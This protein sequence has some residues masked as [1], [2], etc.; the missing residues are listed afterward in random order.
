MLKYM[1]HS[2][3]SNHSDTN[4]NNDN[5]NS[6]SQHSASNSHNSNSAF[7]MNYLVVG[8]I[9][10]ALLAGGFL[11]GKSQSRNTTSQPISSLGIS[12]GANLNN[13]SEQ[14]VKISDQEIKNLFVEWNAALQTKNPEV[15]VKKYADDAVLL[16]TLSNTP[17]TNPELIK[18]YF[19]EFLLKQPFGTINTSTVKSDCNT[20]YDVG[21][22]T[23]GI[24]DPKTGVK[25][26]VPARYSYI[27]KNINGKWL[28]VHHH[29]S[30]M[31]E[32]I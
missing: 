29:S 5:H 10:L 19:S 24:T 27:Y 1:N 14:C 31:P 32:K 8:L 12:S 6:N 26:S 16:P 25:S 3:N 2:H 4:S 11:I 15:V 22:Y 23:F 9:G 13:K 28:I 20:A 7:G 17:R 21:T 18:E 30:A